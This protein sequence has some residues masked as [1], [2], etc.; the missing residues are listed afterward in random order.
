LPPKLRK[1]LTSAA[2]TLLVVLILFFGYLV[3]V[4]G[5]VLWGFEVKLKSWPL[6]IHGAPFTLRVGDDI[7][8]VG[9]MERLQRRGYVEAPDLIPLPGQWKRSDADLAIFLIH[10]PLKGLGIVTGP[11][12]ISLDWKT[13]RSIR[14]QRSRENV[15]EIVLEPELLDIIPARGSQR[16][17]CRP[18]RLKSI[19]PLLVSAILLTEDAR[20]YSH[21]GIDLISIRH[22]LKTNF[23]ARRY[24]LGASTITQQLIR[25][26]LL[27]PKK[28]L[29]RKVNEIFLAMI[30]DAIYSKETILRAY[31]NRV[32][33]GHWGTFPVHGVGT[34]STLF[35]G[36]DQRELEPAECALL[37]AIIQAPNLIN[38]HKNPRRARG[39]RNMILGLLFKAGKITRAQYDRGLHARLTMRR[40]G[41]PPVKAGLFL[42]LV[43]ES[44]DEKIGRN[45]GDYGPRDVLTSLDPWVQKRSRHILSAMGKPFVDTYLISASPQ[46]GTIRAL[47]APSSGGWSGDG[48]SP[49]AILPLMMIPA[50]T[51]DKSGRVEFTLASNVY[52]GTGR[53]ISVTVREAFSRERPFLIQRVVQSLGPE[54]ILGV[55]KEFGVRAKFNAGNALVVT[56]MTPMKMAQIYAVLATLGNAGALRPGVRIIDGGEIDSREARVRVGVDPAVLFMVNHLLKPLDSISVGSVRSDQARD[57][58][59]CFQARDDGGIWSIVYGYHRLLLLRIRGGKPDDRMIG[60]ITRSLLKEQ[61]F[62]PIRTYAPPPG[63]IFRKICTKS[64]LR[65]TSLCPRIVSEPFFKGTQPTEWCPLRHE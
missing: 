37:A 16:S 24:V 12:L 3:V 41:A 23:K 14:L 20:F 60:R 18:L 39:R 50:L 46:T 25:M 30:A 57:R 49:A 32:Y 52:V 26:T 56:P 40:P 22:A 36:K 61:A 65:S 7:D 62:G 17:L 10:S 5:M 4:A 43:R 63:I 8:R 51:P 21:R 35:F 64:G 9:L 54:K 55:L 34:A 2:H 53:G 6:F 45:V 15:D 38:P 19:N 28:T 59:S 33:L 13:V 47:I 44:I 31:L 27:T 42:K 1:I 11:V 48:G 58:L 29:W